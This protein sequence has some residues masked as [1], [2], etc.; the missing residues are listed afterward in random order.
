MSGLS[1]FQEV[2]EAIRQAYDALR[3][4]GEAELPS[5]ANSPTVKGWCIGRLEA[6]AHKSPPCVCWIRGGGSIGEVP[7][8]TFVI[9]RDDM[10]SPL[11]GAETV[12]SCVIAGTSERETELMWHAVLRSTRAV[13][14]TAAGPQDFDWV[15]QK[16][17]EAGYVNAG[18]EVVLQL[19]DW[20]FI[21]PSEVKRTAVILETSHT[22][23]FHGAAGG[24]HTNASHDE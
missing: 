15:T 1:Q 20:P 23:Q 2:I 18:V 9:Q 7:R 8:N 10:L 13:L 22:D 3:A 24:T 5:L 6:K 16:E 19:F 12:I 17:E 4:D 21:V 14:G 11:Y